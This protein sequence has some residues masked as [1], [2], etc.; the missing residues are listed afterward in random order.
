MSGGGLCSI[1]NTKI[2][3]VSDRTQWQYLASDRVGITRCVYDGGASKKDNPMA[4]WFGLSGIS[5][6]LTWLRD[7]R[8]NVQ[9][10]TNTPILNSETSADST[11]M[12]NRDPTS[13]RQP[14]PGTGTRNNSG[15][16]Q[17]GSDK[18][19][20]NVAGSSNG[21]AAATPTSSQDNH[22]KE[23]TSVPHVTPVGTGGGT[24]QTT[25]VS[26]PQDGRRE[27]S[28]DFELAMKDYET[29]EETTNCKITPEQIINNAKV[30]IGTGVFKGSKFAGGLKKKLK[31]NQQIHEWI[32]FKL[33][34]KMGTATDEKYWP[35]IQ[36]E[37]VPTLRSR[38]GSVV[39][40]MQG[41]F[42]GK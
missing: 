24:E 23:Q 17:K 18:G 38:R 42:L 26:S 30:H 28:D 2:D 11:N 22:N 33:G 40:A 19:E 39:G 36:R 27:N 6:P 29:H 20:S 7:S 4:G 34:I 21:H 16:R 15:K 31:E 8:K 3:L 35:K 1:H 32:M 12:R 41:R 5:S 13:K 25:A 14:P 9:C 10:S 37:I